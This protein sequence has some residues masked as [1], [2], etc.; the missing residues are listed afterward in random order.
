MGEIDIVARD[1]ETVVFCEVKYR[2]DHAAGDPAAA[3]DY[4]KQQKIFRVAQWYLQAHRLPEETP[5]RF[6]VMAISGTGDSVQMRWI[7]DA[8]GS[9]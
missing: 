8:F 3:V 4:R 9:W 2:Y 6:D 7:P 5:C 1:G